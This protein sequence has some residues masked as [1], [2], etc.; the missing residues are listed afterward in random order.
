MSS[1]TL[2]DH[3]AVSNVDLDEVLR[4]PKAVFRLRVLHA[5]RRLLADQGLSVSMN[6]IAAAAG[7]GRR[8]LFRYFHSRDA[9]VAEAVSDALTRY[10]AS[11]TET[12][13][14]DLL[15]TDWLEALVVR[16]HETVTELG[17]GF[18]QIVAAS[19]NEL[20]KELVTANRRR[21][22]DRRKSTATVART[23]WRKAGGSGPVPK[24]VVDG[25][26]LTI[27]SFA[28]RSMLSD[29][30][31]DPKTLARTTAVMLTNLLNSEIKTRR[32]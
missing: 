14:M 3:D 32:R 4:D 13:A 17:V 19:D 21:R 12:P 8:S 2:R 29:Y 7:V 24:V 26:A 16:F 25:F 15:L 30:G 31:S 27:S 5:T 22:D 9:L 11:L 23:A 28:T 20:S 10:H 1:T 6:D 18:W